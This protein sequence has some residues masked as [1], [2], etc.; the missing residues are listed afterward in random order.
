MRQAAEANERCSLSFFVLYIVIFFRS[1][2]PTL[3]SLCIIVVVR[4]YFVCGFFFCILS[5]SLLFVL[6]VMMMMMMP[7]CH[8][9]HF[10]FIVYA[11]L[12][13]VPQTL[14][15]SSIRTPQEFKES[16]Q[17]TFNRSDF[18]GY[19]KHCDAIF[20]V[21]IGEIVT[22]FTF[23]FFHFIPQYCFVAAFVWLFFTNCSM[24][25]ENKSGK[26]DGI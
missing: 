2:K 10:N 3:H 14:T 24:L 19:N 11:P 26:L 22:S 25:E 9:I 15:R 8:S 4:L 16:I 1:R 23:F 20:R 17:Q 5:F 13:S 12:L 6:C 21:I 7:R 18:L